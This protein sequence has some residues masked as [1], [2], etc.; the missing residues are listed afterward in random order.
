M[1]IQQA[2]VIAVALLVVLTNTSWSQEVQI[3]SIGQ[4]GSISWTGPY[5]SG[6]YRVQWSSSLTTGTWCNNWTPLID[7]QAQSGMTNGVSVPMYYRVVWSGTNDEVAGIWTGQAPP[8]AQPIYGYST[9]YFNSN[10]SINISY[11]Y[12]PFGAGSFG[13]YQVSGSSLLAIIVETNGT[14]YCLSG[15]IDGQTMRLHQT[16]KT[17]EG[18]ILEHDEGMIYKQ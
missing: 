8:P 13:A 1:K 3:E 16:R 11:P 6:V 18:F 17:K 14:T 2:L 12:S 10:G 9:Y 5:T 7:M 15:E 4:N